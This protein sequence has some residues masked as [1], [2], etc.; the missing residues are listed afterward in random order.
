[1]GHP[2]TLFGETD[3]ERAERLKALENENEGLGESQGFALA[4]GHEVKNTFLGKENNSIEFSKDEDEED[5]DDDEKDDNHKDSS[6]N[7]PHFTFSNKKRPTDEYKLILKYF[8]GLLKEWEYELN[9]R[10]DEIKHTAKG[11]MDTKTQKQ[12]KDYIRPLFK[13]CRKREVPYDILGPLVKIVDYCEEGEFVKAYDEYNSIAIGNAP[14]PMGLTM[15]GIHE[16]KAREKISSSNVA[17]V[18]NNEMQR[19]Y[20]TSVK[21]LIT[22][23]QKLRPDVPPSKKVL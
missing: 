12:C 22:F 2:I 1:M 17:H 5:D 23:A 7:Y 9:A 15:V 18:M 13:L 11:K 19:K 8:R 4:H 10:P 21:R 20:L 14:W 6:D 3:K 16:R